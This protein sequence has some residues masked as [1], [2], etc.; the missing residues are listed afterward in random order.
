[1]NDLPWS[2]GMILVLLAA[3]G[4][5]YLICVIAGRFGANDEWDTVAETKRRTAKRARH[6]SREHM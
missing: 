3:I 4:V 6:L 1:M 5:P 2:H